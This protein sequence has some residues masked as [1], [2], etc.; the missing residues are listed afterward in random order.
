MPLCPLSNSRGGGRA[1]ARDESICTPGRPTLT[2]E[3]GTL[4]DDQTGQPIDCTQGGCGGADASCFGGI[5][6]GGRNGYGD[7][8]DCGK[9]IHAPSGNT[10]SLTFTYIALESGAGCPQPG[11]DTV[12]VYDGADDRA[13][14]LGSFSGALSPPR[15]PRRARFHARAAAQRLTAAPAPAGTEEPPPLVSTGPDLFVRFQTDTGNFGF[16]MESVSDDPGFYVDWHFIQAVQLVRTPAARSPHSRRFPRRG[17][18][19]ALAQRT[20]AQQL[21]AKAAGSAGGEKRA[22]AAWERPAAFA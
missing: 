8:L 7:N 14:V 3:T 12:T 6:S 2:A 15:H 22:E 20:F 11:C 18:L 17:A 13:P 5:C 10:I 16:Q 1:Q 19:A 21:R 9:H 4:S